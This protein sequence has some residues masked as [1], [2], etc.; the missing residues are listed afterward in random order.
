MDEGD[1]KAEKKQDNG[2]HCHI[3]RGGAGRKGLFF[4][5][6]TPNRKVNQTK[7]IQKKEKESPTE[8]RGGQEDNS[9]HSSQLTVTAI[10]T[11]VRFYM[12]AE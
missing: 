12:K 3:W 10:S 8:R 9:T 2:L 5:A 1:S 11:A 7:N 6:T 4:N